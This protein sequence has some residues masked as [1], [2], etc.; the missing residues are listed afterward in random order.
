MQENDTSALQRRMRMLAFAVHSQLLESEPLSKAEAARLERMIRD[1]L[2]P[3]EGIAVP[4][5][6]LGIADAQVC[7][8]A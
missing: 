7:G 2:A 4:K 6:T 5:K 8:R 3:D 1:G